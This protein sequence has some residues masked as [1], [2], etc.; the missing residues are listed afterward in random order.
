M[1]RRLLVALA[2]VGMVVAGLGC[3]Q[4]PKRTTIAVIPKA[5][6]F[7]FWPAVIEGAKAAAKERDVDVTVR[8]ASNELAITEQIEIVTAMIAQEVDGIV[9]APLDAEALVPVVE[10]AVKAG[11]PV[12][13]IDSGINTENIV[14]FVATDNYKGGVMGA[15]RLAEII[16]KKGEVALIK[17]IKG[18]ASTEERERGFLET[19]KKYEPDVTVVAQQYAQGTTAEG[20]RVATD[21]LTANANLA[22]IFAVNEPGAEGALQAAKGKNIKIVGFDASDLLVS[23]IR[24]GT[25]DSTI[26]QAPFDMG[27][28]GLAFLMDHL[29]K[30]QGVP[31]KFNTPIKLV[32]KDNIDT[33][34]IQDHLAAYKDIRE[35]GKKA[36]K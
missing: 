32:Q 33:K 22:G 1:A 13:I 36:P 19:I 6:A 4:G 30:K 20:T 24:E 34:E 17:N 21:I 11:I 10:R 28:K 2:V 15:E 8:A 29:T 5:K 7:R 31:K 35:A 16:G 9:L 18:S 12:V 27:F 3:D 14:S 25:L 26:V 23:G